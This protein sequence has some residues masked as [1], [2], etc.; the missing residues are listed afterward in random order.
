MF[1]MN[2]QQGAKVNFGAIDQE[3]EG[4]KNIEKEIGFL[5]I[6]EIICSKI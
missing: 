5:F 1:F 4:A 2:K 3:Y 6:I